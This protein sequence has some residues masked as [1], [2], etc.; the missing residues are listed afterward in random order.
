MFTLD[1]GLVK[2]WA[3]LVSENR[4]PKESIP[5]LDNLIEVVLSIL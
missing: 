5:E 2:I 4:Y 1:S 3:R